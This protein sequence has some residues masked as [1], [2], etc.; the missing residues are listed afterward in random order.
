[1]ISV[2]DVPWMA[3]TVFFQLNHKVISMVLS[4]ASHNLMLTFWRKKNMRNRIR[5]TKI[6]WTQKYPRIINNQNKILFDNNFS[7]GPSILLGMHTYP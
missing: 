5:R 6:F 3:V 2:V 1:M 4:V 7:Q